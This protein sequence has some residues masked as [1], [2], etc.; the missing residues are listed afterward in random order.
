MLINEPC[1]IKDAEVVESTKVESNAEKIMVLTEE[2][3]LSR[4]NMSSINERLA[5]IET[6]NQFNQRLLERL[7][8]AVE[9]K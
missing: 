9:K 8:D 6:Q 3:K 5:R 4:A 7:A 2:I 1:Y